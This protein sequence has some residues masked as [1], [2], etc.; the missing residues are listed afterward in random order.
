M[1]DRLAT[2]S[3][4]PPDHRPD[5]KGLTPL[6]TQHIT[7]KCRHHHTTDIAF[8]YATEALRQV[9]A[10]QVKRCPS[11]TVSLAVY[12]TDPHVPA[13]GDGKP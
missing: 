12:V 2:E 1:T 6:E 11:A 8:H 10:A 4:D 13:T 3:S 7:A 9:Y 5:V